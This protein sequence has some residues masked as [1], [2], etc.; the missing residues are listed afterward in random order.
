MFGDVKNPVKPDT[1]KSAIDSDIMRAIMQSMMKKQT[2][3]AHGQS[4][5][6]DS[7][8]TNKVI[9]ENSTDKVDDLEEWVDVSAERASFEKNPQEKDSRKDTGGSHSNGPATVDLPSPSNPN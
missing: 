4:V 2:G 9:S 6:H 1:V 7:P 8:E 3:N 5:T